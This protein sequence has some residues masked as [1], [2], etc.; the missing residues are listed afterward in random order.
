MDGQALH[1][2]NSLIVKLM[3]GATIY[4]SQI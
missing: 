4:T 3:L 1:K 2:K